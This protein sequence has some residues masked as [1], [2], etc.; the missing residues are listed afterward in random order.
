VTTGFIDDGRR[1]EG[2]ASRPSSWV[3]NLLIFYCGVNA[4][5]L[6]IEGGGFVSIGTL[7]AS[8]WALVAGLAAIA[9][10]FLWR[11][12]RVLRMM[13]LESLRAR[14]AALAT[15]TRRLSLSQSKSIAAPRRTQAVSS[16]RSF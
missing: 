4:L 9:I 13:R 16:R 12:A 3:V 1:D 11:A 7:R 5:F 10:I 8:Y 2:L 15:T 6:A 14:K